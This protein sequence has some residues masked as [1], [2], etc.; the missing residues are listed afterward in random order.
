MLR[1]LNGFA[2]GTVGVRPLLAERL[3]DALNGGRDPARAPARVG[4]EWPTSLRSATSPPTLFADVE[5]APKEALA[6]VNN[7]SFSTGLRGARA[8]R[9][10]ARWSTR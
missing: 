5:L 3:V 6:L 2:K 9:R 10:R 8:R 7:N 4:R 1:L